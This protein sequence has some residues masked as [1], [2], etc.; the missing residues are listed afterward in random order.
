VGFCREADYPRRVVKVLLDAVFGFD[1][2]SYGLVSYFSDRFSKDLACN[3]VVSNAVNQ[4]DSVYSLGD[5]KEP[6]QGLLRLSL[7]YCSIKG[8]GN[9]FR[10]G[11]EF[12]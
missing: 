7:Y 3:L 8:S 9:S 4:V 5:V 1:S 6:V 12:G 11:F 10:V 2:L